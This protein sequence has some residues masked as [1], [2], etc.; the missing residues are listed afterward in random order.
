MR[1]W[2][3]DSTQFIVTEA[4]LF[5][6]LSPR[7]TNASY[8]DQA[9]RNV[10]CIAEVL[11]NAERRP[12]EFSSLGFYVIAPAEQIKLNL[13]RTE[14]SEQSI[15]AKVERRV[16]EYEPPDREKKDAWLHDWFLPTLEH[17]DIKCLSW[18][19]IIDDLRGRDEIFGTELSNFYSECL[20][21]NR[22]Q[23]PELTTISLPLPS[24]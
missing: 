23:E 18:E 15:R 20:R 17:I 16:S 21:F 3:E 5:S 2:S 1:N 4:K 6:P 10:A 9:A 24:K 22:P 12:K 14:L 13:F 7:V 19:Q 11:A 8:F